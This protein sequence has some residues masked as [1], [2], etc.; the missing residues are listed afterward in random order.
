MFLAKK[1][2]FVGQNRVH[3][4]VMLRIG[5]LVD[6]RGTVQEAEIQES[7]GPD[8]DQLA[9]NALKQIHLNSAKCDR[10]HI[11][12]FFEFQIW[13]APASHPDQFYSFR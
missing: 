4:N 8:L 5:G 6:D 10:K 2:E 3:G 1:D 9:L 13:F 11:S 12:S 7:G